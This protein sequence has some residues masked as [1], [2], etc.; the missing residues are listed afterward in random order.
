MGLLTR[1]RRQGKEPGF[2]FNRPL[3]LIQS[4]DWGRVGVRDEEG[5]EELRATGVNLGERAYD[6]YSLETASDVSALH[7]ALSSV[8]DSVGRS[9]CIG[10]NFVV[11]NVDFAKSDPQ[12]ILKPLK[13][14]L[15]VRWSRPGL[16]EAYR[17]G[18]KA[19]VLAPALH[20]TTHFC[21][22]AVLL[23]LEQGGERARLMRTLWKSETPYIHWRMPWVG[24]E[25]WN[26]E[27]RASQ[28]FLTRDEQERLIR[29]GGQYFQE[30][31]G[32]PAVSACAPG[33]RAG[34]TTFQLWQEQGIRVAQGGP[35]SMRG[36]HFDEYEMLH[37]YRSIDFEPALHPEMRWEDCFAAGKEWLDR[38]LPLIISVHSINFHSTL[39]PFRQKTLAL[40][41]EFL[42]ALRSAYPDLL[43]I[44][45]KQLLDIVKS[46]SYEQGNGIRVEVARIGRGVSA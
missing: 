4:D 32:H 13:D 36:P 40:L 3:V 44:D 29:Q 43:Y 39:A 35:G 30:F 16:F 33:Y 41:R 45:D 17:E 28:R 18:I 23:A 27:R 10:M 22:Q 20:G 9:P 31:F 38:G 1:L 46:G 11:A 8:H 21:Q 26:P 25:Y 42:G 15:P 37:T 2:R 19:G 12:I 34:N 5:R 6:L 7:E 14:G 24:Y